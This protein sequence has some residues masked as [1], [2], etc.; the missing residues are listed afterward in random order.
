[1]HLFEWVDPLL[2]LYKTT[3]EFIDIFKTLLYAPL[4][5]KDI[6][7]AVWAEREEMGIDEYIPIK[8]KCDCNMYQIKNDITGEE[9]CSE[10]GIVTVANIDNTAEWNAFLGDDQNKVRCGMAGNVLLSS[11]GQLSTSIKGP[12][13]PKFNILYRFHNSSNM[14]YSDKTLLKKYEDFSNI[15]MLLGISTNAIE[16]AKYLFMNVYKHG[17]SRRQGCLIGN[18]AACLYIG[19]IDT[20]FPIDKYALVTMLEI[21]IAYLNTGIND[22]HLILTELGIKVNTYQDPLDYISLILN[23]LQ[24]PYNTRKLVIEELKKLSFRNTDPF[25]MI[26]T[27][28]RRLKYKIPET[29]LTEHQYKHA[30]VTV[31]K[32][33][34]S[35][36]EIG[37]ICNSLYMRPIHINPIKKLYN[38]GKYTIKE[39]FTLYA[40]NKG[41]K[42]DLNRI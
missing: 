39:A 32:E 6:D 2:F 35:E 17:R 1:M 15:G 40:Q 8:N 38:T 28:L 9:I 29:I 26:C 12:N 42:I 10:C 5:V 4:P 22:V 23:K 36:N 7:S 37:N 41:L 18:F 16:R 31:E 3:D 11:S 20:H 27:V 14:S 19:C 21:E 24:L 25:V 13:L 34:P 30:L 33:N